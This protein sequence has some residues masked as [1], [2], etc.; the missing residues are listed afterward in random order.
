MGG[1]EEGRQTDGVGA[2]EFACSE[3]GSV[4]YH[5]LARVYLV[6]SQNTKIVEI[7]VLASGFNHASRRLPPR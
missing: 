6:P 3:H 7:A 2:W 1:W 4:Y 5:L